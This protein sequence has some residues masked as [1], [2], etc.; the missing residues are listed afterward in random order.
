MGKVHAPVAL[1]SSNKVDIMG[2]R[3][4][5]LSSLDIKPLSSCNATSKRDF[6]LSLWWLVTENYANTRAIKWKGQLWRRIIHNL[7]SCEVPG[8]LLDYW[9]EGTGVGL[10][11]T[12]KAKVEEEGVSTVLFMLDAHWTPN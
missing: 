6:R 3:F 4:C 7:Q 9:L 8:Q 5:L 2:K 11:V 12:N 10:G 1:S